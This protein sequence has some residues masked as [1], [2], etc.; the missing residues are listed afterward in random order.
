MQ[1]SDKRQFY[2]L[3]MLLT[4]L[5]LVCFSIMFQ[6]PINEEQIEVKVQY[7]MEKEKERG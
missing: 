7:E 1:L 6:V 5:C 3:L 4:H 2:D